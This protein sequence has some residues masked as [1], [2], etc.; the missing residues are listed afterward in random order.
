MYKKAYGEE[1]ETLKQYRKDFEWFQAS[2][3]ELLN[4]YSRK[5]IAILNQAVI[6]YDKNSTQ[7]LERLKENYNDI[8][9]I[10]VEYVDRRRLA[11]IL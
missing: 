8:S 5:F 2:F 6:D 4:E 7:L 3:D 10:L 11:H 9:P 1:L